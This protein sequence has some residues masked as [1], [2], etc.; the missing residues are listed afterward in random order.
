[1]TKTESAYLDVDTTFGP[2]YGAVVPL[3]RT[4]APEATPVDVMLD[5]DFERFFEMYKRLLTRAPG[6]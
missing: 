6:L 2:N 5:L 1:V 3:D 4:L